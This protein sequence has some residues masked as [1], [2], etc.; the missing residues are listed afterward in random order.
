TVD[1]EFGTPQGEGAVG[2]NKACD[3]SLDDI[4]LE[5]NQTLG[6]RMATRSCKYYLASEAPATV[7]VT[8]REAGVGGTGFEVSDT[9]IITAVNSAP[10]QVQPGLMP[11]F[12]EGADSLV[13]QVFNS[14]DPE[15]QTLVFHIG[16]WVGNQL[17]FVGAK[18]PSGNYK[19]LI[20]AAGEAVLAYCDMDT[21]NGNLVGSLSGPAIQASPIGLASS[22][23]PYEQILVFEADDT[24]DPADY[25]GLKSV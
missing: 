5:H 18:G 6:L 3:P 11:T 4:Q 8:A 7:T 22:L 21:E 19:D 23:S 15:G 12:T 13:E 20:A 1:F 24:F 17:S 25:P 16:R 9:V 10:S 14:V 2:S